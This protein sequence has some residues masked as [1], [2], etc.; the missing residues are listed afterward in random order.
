MFYSGAAVPERKTVHMES[1]CKI[2][3]SSSTLDYIGHLLEVVIVGG[4]RKV[5]ASPMCRPRYVHGL[6]R[7]R[8]TDISL[9]VYLSSD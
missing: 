1:S 9:Y 4:K 5:V 6:R 8:E 7:A 2:H 3:S